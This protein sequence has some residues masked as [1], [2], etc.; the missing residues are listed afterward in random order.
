MRRWLRDHLRNDDLTDDPVRWALAAAF[1]VVLLLGLFGCGEATPAP[2]SR[3]VTG[4]GD[5]R[6]ITVNGMPCI[7]W[8]V[9]DVASDT[10][11]HTYSGLDCDWSER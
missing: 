6:E 1:V 2:G 4:D 9:D 3:V 10:K 11:I 8:A 5:F 7:I